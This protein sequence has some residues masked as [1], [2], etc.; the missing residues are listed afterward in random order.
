MP[1]L[2]EKLIDDSHMYIDSSGQWVHIDSIED[3]GLNVLQE[4]F[5]FVDDSVKQ[6]ILNHF[7]PHDK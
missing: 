1:N 6:K 4:C 7:M 2:L 5:K 3:Y